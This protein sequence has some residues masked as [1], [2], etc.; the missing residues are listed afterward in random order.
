[1]R[2]VIPPSAPCFDSATKFGARP[3]R[4]SAH[5]NP[6]IPT[7]TTRDTVP[8]ATS[9]ALGASQ[10]EPAQNPATVNN[11]APSTMAAIRW[12]A[13]VSRGHNARTMSAPWRAR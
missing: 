12:R 1:V 13:V 7:S 11:S 4:T 10:F 9:G 3:A 8:G 6:G 5:D 2:T